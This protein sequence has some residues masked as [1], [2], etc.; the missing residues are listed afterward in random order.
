MYLLNAMSEQ[1]SKYLT[2]FNRKLGRTPNLFL[3]MMYSD[4]TSIMEMQI[5]SSSLKHLKAFLMLV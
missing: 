1:N 4:N 3:T 5:S 2:Y